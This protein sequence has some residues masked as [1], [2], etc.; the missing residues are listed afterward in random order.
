MEWFKSGAGQLIALV[1]IVGTL[2][3]FGYTGATYVNRLENLER[4][5]EKAKETD[6]DLGEI[7]KR[8]ETLETS[9]EYINKS[10]D[11]ESTGLITKIDNNNESISLLKSQLEGLSVAVRSLEKDV[12]KLEED[13]TNPLAK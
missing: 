7:E 1:T 10:L 6:D 4:K 13:N 9:I 8:F 11:N 2:A 12:E 5:M 3:G